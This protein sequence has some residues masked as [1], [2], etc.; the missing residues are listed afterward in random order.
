MHFNLW[1]SGCWLYQAAFVEKL[2]MKK[3]P[4]GRGM[5]PWRWRKSFAGSATAPGY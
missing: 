2:S 4:R 5:A 1:L 3:L